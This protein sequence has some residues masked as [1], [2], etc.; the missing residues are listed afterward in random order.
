MITPEMIDRYRTIIIRP[1]VTEKS[2]AQAEGPQKRNKYTFLVHA[3][4]NKTEIRQAVSAL[5][6]VRVVSVNTLTV[7]GKE[8]RQ[9]FRYRPGRT[10]TRKKAVVTLAEGQSIDILG[11]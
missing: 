8:R 10:A 1:V 3:S 4:A 5:W 6:N 7:R 9:S 11:G 2:M